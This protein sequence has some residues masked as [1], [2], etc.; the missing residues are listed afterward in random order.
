MRAAAT[1]DDV[2][3]LI[4]FLLSDAAAPLHG[5]TLPLYSNVT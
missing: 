5:I 4:L 3:R 1:A 2:A